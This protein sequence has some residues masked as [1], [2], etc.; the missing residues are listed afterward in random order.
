MM[1]ITFKEILVIA[2]VMFAILVVVRGDKEN[3]PKG[4]SSRDI[5]VDINKENKEQN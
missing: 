1:D 5:H 2:V 4:K 3:H